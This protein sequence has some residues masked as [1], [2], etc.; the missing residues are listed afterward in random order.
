MEITKHSTWH[1]RRIALGLV[2]AALAISTTA[3]SAA[4][5]SFDR[6][7]HVSGPVTV[8]VATGAGYIHVMPGDPSSVHITAHIRARGPFNAEA[9]VRSI[10]NN[11]PIQQSGSI[12]RIGRHTPNGVAIDYDITVPP[13]TQLNA[14]TGSG[15]LRIANINGSV[16]ARTGSG[17]IQADGLSNHIV[18]QTG[19]GSIRASFDQ[20]NDVKA[21]TGSGSITLKN[22]QGLLS[23][24][25]GSG[26]IHVSGTPSAGW[27]LR[28]GSGSVTM[29][30]GAAHYSINASTGSGTIHSDQPISMTGKI[31]RR[32]ITGDVNGGGPT[33]RIVT[34]SGDIRIH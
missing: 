7:L 6:T 19:S 9:R 17:S 16:T 22:V 12:I 21:Q 5:G 33:V 3:C 11:P 28:T 25:T 32:H 8:R 10:E 29:D 30:T 20:S 4:S 31:G 23:A 34:G 26:S 14:Q 2:A 13:S 24:Q 1:L 15:D 27:N 18:L